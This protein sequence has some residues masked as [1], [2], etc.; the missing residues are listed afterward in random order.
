MGFDALRI[1]ADFHRSCREVSGEDSGHGWGS[2]AGVL[3]DHGNSGHMAASPAA[4][5]VSIQILHWQRL[6]WEVSWGKEMS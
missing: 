3:S 2:V 6:A 4:N 1:A 5:S